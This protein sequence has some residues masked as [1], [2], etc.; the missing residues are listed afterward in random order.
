MDLVSASGKG[1]EW[2]GSLQFGFLFSSI[3]LVSRRGYVCLD[4]V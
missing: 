4:C 3:S 2:K 1:V